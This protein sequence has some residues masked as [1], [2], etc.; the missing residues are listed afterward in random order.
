MH[1]HCPCSLGGK[2]GAKKGTFFVNPPDDSEES[3]NHDDDKADTIV[4]G[5]CVQCPCIL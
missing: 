4:M 5:C 1:W 2:V 3:N